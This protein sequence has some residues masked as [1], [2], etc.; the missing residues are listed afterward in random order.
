MFSLTT[1]SDQTQEM[2]KWR[3]DPAVLTPLTE[4]SSYRCEHSAYD[5][6]VLIVFVVKSRQLELLSGSSI[7]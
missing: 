3:G 4:K 6:S 7:S 2:T 5:L 1:A